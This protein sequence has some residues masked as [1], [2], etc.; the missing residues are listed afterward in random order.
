MDD[1]N[2]RETKVGV[3]D[4]AVAILLAFPRGDLTLSPLEIA[5]R[6]ALPLPTV[7]RLAQ[8]LCDHGLLMKDGQRFCLGMTLA[9]LGMLAL[10][11]SDVRRQALRH[12]K[13]LNEQTG[14][15][16]ELHLRHE[17]TRLVI[18]VV[19]SPHN[20]RPFAE[21]GTPLPLHRGAAGKVL[22][23]WLS[24]PERDALAA[25]SAARFGNTRPFDLQ[26]FAA[27]LER[28]RSAGWATSEGER[29]AGVAAIA[30][31]IFA[32]DGQAAGAV[33]LVAP[34]ARLEEAQRARYTPFVCE[35]ARRTSYDLGFAGREQQLPRSDE[36]AEERG[37][38]DDSG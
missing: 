23:A 28:V 7:Y 29:I 11:G 18:E 24:P 8:A 4:K 19:S 12:L 21:V 34:S 27:E 32:A 25:A 9:R 26:Q 37:E 14:E 17:D 2:T 1:P 35:T 31:P 38:N 5:A 36:H 16:A 6:T 13:W 3:L 33:A 22:L 20:L 15:N 10:E 30:A